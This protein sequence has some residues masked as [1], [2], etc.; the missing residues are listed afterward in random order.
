M[1]E[2]YKGR[3]G[4]AVHSIVAFLHSVLKCL[5]VL[6]STACLSVQNTLGQG[7]IQCERK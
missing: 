1:G 2:I 3:M 4:S 6:A 5:A 7:S